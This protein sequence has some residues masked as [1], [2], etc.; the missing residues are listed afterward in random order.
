MLLTA[1]III[2]SASGTYAIDYPF[3]WKVK[4]KYHAL[5]NVVSYYDREKKE[6]IFN[7]RY[8]ESYYDIVDFDVSN[9]QIPTGA[10][11]YSLRLKGKHYD[12][13]E[14]YIRNLNSQI[15]NSDTGVKISLYIKNYNPRKDKLYYDDA[16]GLHEIK[17]LTKEEGERKIRQRLGKK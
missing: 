10:N 3:F 8:P 2:L 7:C 12:L 17:V 13:V 4:I 14:D 6:L 16:D 5:S 15:E 9:E 11:V 1:I